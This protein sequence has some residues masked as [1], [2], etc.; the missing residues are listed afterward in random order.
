M[1]FD[2]FIKKVKDN[3]VM[4]D[5]EKQETLKTEFLQMHSL[6]NQDNFNVFLNKLY[7]QLFDNIAALIYTDDMNVNAII[8]LKGKITQSYES[9]LSVENSIKNIKSNKEEKKLENISMEDIINFYKETPV[10]NER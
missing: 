2:K 9:I 1:L 8:K 5:E 4:T 3:V 6:I 7:Y 10:A